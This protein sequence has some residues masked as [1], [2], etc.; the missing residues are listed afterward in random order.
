MIGELIGRLPNTQIKKALGGFEAAILEHINSVELEPG[1]TE[2][3]GMLYEG[4]SG[5]LMYA[6]ATGDDQNN[7][8]RVMNQIEL[9]DFLVEAIKQAK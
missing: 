4:E 6:I 8:K 2:S 9:K 3:F 7:I 5:V 1:E